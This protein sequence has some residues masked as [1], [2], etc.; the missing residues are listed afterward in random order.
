MKNLWACLSLF[1]ILISSAKATIF[2]VD[3]GGSNSNSGL[4]G[5]PWLTIQQ[6]ASTAQAG[7]TV[8][9]QAGTYSEKI[10]F[11][12]S[13]I[14]NALITFI[15]VGSVIIEEPA[16]TTVWSG[17]FNINTKSYIRIQN[18]AIQNAYWF[19]IY[20]EASD[21]IYLE[22]NSTYNTGASGISVWH[23]SYVYAS[24][25][26]VRKACYQSLTTSNAQECISFSGVSNFEIHH[27][28]V[29]ESGGSTNGGE[30]IDTKENCSNGKVYNNIVHDLIR[31]GIYVD[32]WDKIL[33]EVD[34]YNN[35]VYNCSDGIAISSEDSGT[36]M[37]V[38]VYNN[39]T[40]SNSGFGII[41]S[42]Y[43]KD[44]PRKNIAIMNNTVYNN[45]FGDGDPNWG[46]GIIVYSSHVSNISIFNNIVSS[47]DAMQI[48]DNSGVASV[49]V[50]KNLIYGYKGLNWT[51][52]VKGTNAIEANPLF[53]DID[54]ADNSIGNLDDNMNVTSASPAINQ[55]TNTNAP[56]F[57]FDNYIR[58]AEGIVDI[59][60]YEANSVPLATKQSIASA[61][62]LIQI[63][64]N[65]SNGEFNVKVLKPVDSVEIFDQT[66][67]KI[68]EYTVTNANFLKISINQTG[69]YLIRVSSGSVSQ[70]YKGIVY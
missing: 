5:S 67:N 8:Y 69:L 19:G 58:P 51:G 32:S 24:H 45:G 41:V 1:I 21:H 44:G 35:R 55:G 47:N 53:V 22:N 46:G 64:P 3:K 39:I 56:T 34:V 59:G 30:G 49:S 27:N 20:L 66:G 11:Q 70:T 4:M 68:Q 48:S 23:S 37:N 25:N 16:N 15:G 33:Q 13:G 61:E 17:T 18:F 54:G 14:E 6:A 9:V 43:V 63:Y 26:T 40:Y 42:N 52:E 28:E 12:H 57:D 10:T 36:V 50:N 60:A 2:Y 65:P 31:L 62:Q 7:D 29:Y 38:N